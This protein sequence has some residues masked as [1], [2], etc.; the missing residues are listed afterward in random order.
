MVTQ[1]IDFPFY[2]SVPH[3]IGQLRQFAFHLAQTRKANQPF[4]SNLRSN[5][6]L[7]WAKL[8]NEELAPL[9]IL[10]NILK[11]NDEDKFIIS[12]QA[13]PGPDAYLTFNNVELR[14]QI[15]VSDPEWG[16]GGEGGYIDFLQN[17]V[18]REGGVAWGGGGTR[19]DNGTILSSPKVLNSH[20]RIT[21]CRRGIWSALERKAGKSNGANL[22]HVYARDYLIQTMDEGFQ[23]VVEMVIES[24]L[25][26]KARFD[27]ERAI[28]VTDDDGPSFDWSSN[29]K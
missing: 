22:L 17:E 26:Q 9:A 18:L 27:F 15:T 20:E 2:R 19:K 14:I 10:A 8:W 4:S 28:F 12:E 1:P 5:K 29:P 16:G 13:A 23:F 7:P 3:T 25:L 6:K 21:A 24:F 11:C